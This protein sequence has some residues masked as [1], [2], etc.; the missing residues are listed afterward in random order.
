VPFGC[1]LINRFSDPSSFRLFISELLEFSNSLEK[2]F[3]ILFF[4]SQNFKSL[5]KNQRKFKLISLQAILKEKRK[6][7]LKFFLESGWKAH[8]HLK[9]DFAK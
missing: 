3:L 2:L 1:F 7:F 8:T 5:K 6:I 4:D 9:I